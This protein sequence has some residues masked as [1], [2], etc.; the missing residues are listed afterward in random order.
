[1]RRHSH[2]DASCEVW[3]TRFDVCDRQNGRHIHKA[4]ANYRWKGDPPTGKP[5]KITMCTISH[6]NNKG[7]TDEDYLFSDNDR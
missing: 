1:M 3:L 4:N 6:W 5:F 7:V 2:P